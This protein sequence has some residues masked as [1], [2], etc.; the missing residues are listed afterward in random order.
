MTPQAE[1]A[2]IDAIIAGLQGLKTQAAELCNALGYNASSRLSRAV[3]AMADAERHA[4]TAA[5]LHRATHKHTAE[6]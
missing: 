2:A 1:I 3:D 4:A 6:A 5:N